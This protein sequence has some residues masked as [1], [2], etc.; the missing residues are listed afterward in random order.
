MN[1]IKQYR[2]FAFEIEHQELKETK[3]YNAYMILQK[4]RRDEIRI[5]LKGKGFDY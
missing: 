5:M 4:Q 1:T 3:D 2:L